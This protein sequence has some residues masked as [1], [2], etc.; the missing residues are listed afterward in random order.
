MD[1]RRLRI[2]LAGA[3]ALVGA[4]ALGPAAPGALADHP[5]EPDLKT[6]RLSQSDLVMD[7][8]GDRVLL[9][10]T[11]EVGNRGA[12]PLEVVP[13]IET[14]VCQVEPRL[15]EGRLAFQRLFVDTGDNGFDRE[16]DV[17]ADVVDAGCMQYH[18]PHNHWHVVDFA[19]YSLFDEATGEPAGTGKKAG[20]CLFD[21]NDPFPDLLGAPDEQDYTGAGCGSQPDDPPDLEGISV[22]WSDIYTY[23]TPGQRINVT[24]VPAGRYCL[25]SEANPEALLTESRVANNDAQARIRLRPRRLHVERL[26]GPC[27]N[28]P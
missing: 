15:A 21:N 26:A 23:L 7:R 12:G 14:D 20:F 3:L 18:P 2:R 17:T 8:V 24:G 13:G 19:E 22:G 11:N 6:L 16:E 25:V 10:L 28:G 5:L 4:A 9:R 27:R 1:L